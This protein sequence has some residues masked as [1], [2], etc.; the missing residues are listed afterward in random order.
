[1]TSEERDFLRRTVRADLLGY[2]TDNGVPLLAKQS[3]ND[4][5]GIWEGTTF[6]VRILEEELRVMI[7]FRD[8]ENQTFDLHDPNYRELIVACIKAGKS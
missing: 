5:D 7:A 3:Y 6:H 2:L 4:P 1:M 8:R